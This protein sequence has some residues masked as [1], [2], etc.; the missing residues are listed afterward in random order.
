MKWS[1]DLL[2]SVWEHGR[3]VLEADAS[4]WRQDACGAWMR[5]DQLDHES[6]EFGWSIRNVSIGGAD[7]P[8]NLR[9]FHCRNVFDAASNRP[10]C[11]MTADRTGIAAGEYA[12]PP[13]N[14][15]A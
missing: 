13:R 5:R 12:S 11:R 4:I 7:T 9:P 6:A 14:R 3:A 1:K 2:D 10:H 8:E 15:E